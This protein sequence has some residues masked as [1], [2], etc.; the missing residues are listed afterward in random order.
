MSAV[1]LGVCHGSRSHRGWCRF[2]RWWR[3]QQLRPHASLLHK[4]ALHEVVASQSLG[5]FGVVHRWRAL[6]V[7]A[8]GPMQSGLRWSG[9]VSRRRSSVTACPTRRRQP[10]WWCAGTLALVRRCAHRSIWWPAAMYLVF[11]PPT[12][13]PCLLRGIGSAVCP[14]APKGLPQN[15]AGVRAH[16]SWQGCALPSTVVVIL[17]RFQGPGRYG[18]SQRYGR[19]LQTVPQTVPLQLPRRKDLEHLCAKSL[20]HM[21]GVKGFEPSTPCTPCKCATRLRHTPKP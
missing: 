7:Y 3:Y 14:S 2:W 18:P 4:A 9:L 16:G 11:A 19:N 20:I 12:L 17:H 8:A 13:W 6:R 21:V 10:P 1:A 5:S 15:R